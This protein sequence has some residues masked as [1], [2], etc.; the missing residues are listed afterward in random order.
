MTTASKT[1]ILCLPVAG[2][3]NPFQQLMIGGLNENTGVIAANGATGKFTGLLRTAFRR[4]DYI[5]FD[6]IETYY[7]R[8]YAWLTMISIPWFFFQLFVAKKIFGAR[9]VCTLHN[10]TPHN[11]KDPALHQRVYY[12]FLHRCNWIRVFDNTTISSASELFGVPA[13]RFK[14]CPEGDFTT[15]Y[16]DTIQKKEALDYLNIPTDIRAVLFFGTISRYKGIE[17]L[18]TAFNRMADSK[19]LLLI[20]GRAADQVYLQELKSAAGDRV[21]F[22]PQFIQLDAVQY[23]MRAADFVILPFH[24]IENSGSVI[25][26]MGF[27]KL[28]VAPAKGILP[29]RLK[30]QAAFLYT[31]NGLEAALE[32]AFSTDTETM[33]SIGLANYQLVKEYRWSDFGKLF[34]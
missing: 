6:W 23:Y 20:A 17:T 18:I 7:S 27:K 25:L 15:L 11:A 14:S 34:I 29:A 10:L 19:K 33:N 13:E 2:A 4:P 21:I 16:P 30:A 28:V 22:H 9:I 3:E 32:K 8:R 24:S 26:A 31:E 5:H 12:R 1:T